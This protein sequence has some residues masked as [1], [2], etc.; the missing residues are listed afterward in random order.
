MS[1]GPFHLGPVELLYLGIN[2]TTFVLTVAAL[3]GARR[4]RDS[5]RYRNGQVR[6]IAVEGKVRNEKVRL[7]AQVVLLLMGVPAYLS[8]SPVSIL[9]PFVIGLIALSLLIFLNT[10]G[11]HFDRRRMTVV[12]ERL[13]EA[14]S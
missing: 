5:V 11:D 13:L 10:A 4:D 3:I 7:Y 1:I 9:S 2:V 6:E 14:K 8:A 12:L